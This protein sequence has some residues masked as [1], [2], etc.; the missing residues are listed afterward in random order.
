M[1]L[2]YSVM[3]IKPFLHIN[4]ETLGLSNLSGI[5]TPLLTQSIELLS[6]SIFGGA[7]LQSGRLVH[8]KG[9]NPFK[10]L[11]RKKK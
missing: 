3:L 9:S 5:S 11:I 2:K 1:C 6:G 4:E 7:G 8:G 10:V